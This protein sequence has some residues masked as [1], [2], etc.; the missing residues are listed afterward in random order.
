MDPLLAEFERVN[1]EIQ[2]GGV[3]NDT[4]LLNYGSRTPIFALPTGFQQRKS[5]NRRVGLVP[6]QGL[7]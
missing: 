4:G 6:G 7:G 1:Q 3:D 5:I 2:W